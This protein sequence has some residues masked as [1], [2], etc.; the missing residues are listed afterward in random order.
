MVL[1]ALF[2]RPIPFY[3]DDT[4]NPKLG[5]VW[6]SCCLDTVSTVP[7][8][9]LRWIQEYVLPCMVTRRTVPLIRQAVRDS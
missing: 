1:P 4:S 9:L 2:L 5:L 7:I 8:E 3:D 6:L